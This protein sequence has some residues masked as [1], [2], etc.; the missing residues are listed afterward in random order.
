MAN[1]RISVVIPVY[2]GERFLAEAIESALG[3]TVPPAE[4]VVVDDGSTDESAK[5]VAG[6]L[7]VTLISTPHQGVSA[8]RNAGAAHSSGELLAFL[9]ADDVWAR[10]KLAVQR[11]ALE[12]APGAALVLCGHDYRF[13]GPVPDWFRGPH[14]GAAAGHLMIG[15]L[16]RRDAWIRIGPFATGMH[17]GEDGDWLIRAR[18]MGIPM[19]AVDD[20]LWTYRIHNANSSWQAEGVREGLMRALRASVHRK[21]GET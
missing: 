9:D 3:Q 1:E 14:E 12:G 18:D 2:N 7:G 17:H 10:N 11:S 13:E 19:T 21:R 4:V 20:V 15:A 8:A 16:I 6:I 5:V